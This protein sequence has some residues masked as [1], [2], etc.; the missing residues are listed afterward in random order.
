MCKGSHGIENVSCMS[1]AAGYRRRGFGI[2]RIRVSQRNYD[3]RLEGF[4]NGNFQSATSDAFVLNRFRVGTLIKA[5]PWLEIYSELQDSNAFWK[6]QPKAPPYQSTWDL[7]RAYVDL[8]T[9]AHALVD[10]R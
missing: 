4:S 8:G 7:R 6:D 5:R 3:S 1:G 10:R 9:I 2:V